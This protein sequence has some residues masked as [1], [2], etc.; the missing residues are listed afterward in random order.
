MDKLKH[1]F[2]TVRSNSPILYGI[3]M[4][5]F[6]MAAGCIIGLLVDDR[7]LMGVNVWIK[8]LKFCISGGIYILTFGYLITL[9]P[10]SK[11]KT[12]IINNIVSWT[13]L[14]EIGII[15]VQGARG[16]QSHYNQSSLLDGLLFAAMG[17]LIAI[18]V[19]VMVFFV[20]ETIRLKLKT[21]RAVQIAILMGWIIIIGGSWVG[22][23][24]IGQMAHNVGVP[25]GGAGLPLVNWSTIAG[26]LRV[27][28]FF[29]LHGLQVIPLFAVWVSTKWKT[30]TRNQLIVVTIFGLLYAGW[31]A[32]TFYQAR[33]GM[34]FIAM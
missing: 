32:F 6:I 33:Q 15:V 4:I 23:Q 11:R 25:D 29:G 5:H 21:S 24:M 30:P 34:P 9:Y 18:N 14:V 19:L 16:V 10:F 8:P 17:M 1:V 31:I 12:N 22:G 13:L 20:I 28:H 2:T 26:D 3:V 7:M 27:A